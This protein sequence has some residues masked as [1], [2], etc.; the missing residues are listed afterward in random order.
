MLFIA[1]LLAY[2]KRLSNIFKLVLASLYAS[3]HFF[4]FH[5]EPYLAASLLH[6][7]IVQ[8]EASQNICT[9]RRQSHFQPSTS[10]L[11]GQAVSYTAQQM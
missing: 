1:S 7:E 4:G 5:L 2:S 11:S 9:I 8:I 6:A 3:S 10:D